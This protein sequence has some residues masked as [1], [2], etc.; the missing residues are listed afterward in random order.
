MVMIRKLFPIMLTFAVVTAENI[1]GTDNNLSTETKVLSELE[2]IIV[3]RREEGDALVKVQFFK[4]APNPKKRNIAFRPFDV[5]DDYV[6]TQVRAIDL[7]KGTGGYCSYEYGGPRMNRV[8]LGFHSEINQG[9][10]YLVE[11]YG[12]YYPRNKPT[13]KSST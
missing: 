9:I 6:I 5:P 3:G 7:S 4:M 11:L 8:L 13:T 1:S 2:D 10:D 12:K